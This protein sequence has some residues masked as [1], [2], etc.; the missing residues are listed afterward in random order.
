MRQRRKA[1][2]NCGRTLWVRDSR[3]FRSLQ[4]PFEAFAPISL[5]AVRV[6]L[7]SVDDVTFEGSDHQGRED[8]RDRLDCQDHL[9]RED[10]QELPGSPMDVLLPSGSAESLAGIRK[11]LPEYGKSCWNTESLAGIQKVSP[12]CIN[13]Q[14]TRCACRARQ[15][16]KCL[17]RR[18][19]GSKDRRKGRRGTARPL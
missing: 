13:R 14:L 6:D 1:P 19:A 8:H 15:P 5:P 4:G 12:G 3:P 7:L 18:A 17:N 2:P 16:S 10:H 9:D 11:V